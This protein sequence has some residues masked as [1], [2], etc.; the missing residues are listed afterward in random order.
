[1]AEQTP[2]LQALLKFQELCPIEEVLRVFPFC[3]Q[4]A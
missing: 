3:M 2:R 4:L 1:M